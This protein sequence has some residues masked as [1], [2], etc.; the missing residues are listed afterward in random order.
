MICPVGAISMVEDYEGFLYPEI[1]KDKCVKCN[2]CK[3][4]CSNFN[5]NNSYL[6]K[7]YAGYTKIEKDLNECSSGGMFYI[8]AK[9][10]IENHGIVFGVEFD[11][12]VRAIHNYADNLEDCK[13]FRGSKYVR[14]DINNSYQEVKDFLEDNRLVL[15]TGTPCQCNALK[16]FLKKNYENL[17]LC[18]VICHNNPS[19]KVLKK[20]IEELEE[21]NGKKVK[22]IYFRSKENTWKNQTPIIEYDDGQRQEENSY[23]QAFGEGLLGRQSCFSCVFANKKRVTDFTI[24][25]LWGVENFN[26]NIKEKNGI[27]LFTINSVKAEQLFEKV[28]NELYYEKIESD[29][30]YNNNHYKNTLSNNHRN[31]F[32]KQINKKVSIIK[33]MQKYSKITF[34]DRVQFKIRRTMRKIKNSN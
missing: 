27:S 15:F 6:E 4:I 30:P 3:K 8:L 19:P 7:L 26:L 13:K 1:D 14:S 23:H 21:K 29:A 33:L 5:P 17:I 25:D 11:E 28:K 16:V 20:Y 10:V 9:Y 2:K 24:G 22:N 31:K 34:V 32:Y 12:N 18:D